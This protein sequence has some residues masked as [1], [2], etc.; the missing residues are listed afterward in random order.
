MSGAKRVAV[1]GGS[2]CPP[3]LGHLLA[4]T[5]A[6]GYGLDEVWVFPVYQHRFAKPLQADFATRLRWCAQTFA[7]LGP[8]VV[9][10]DDERELV[11]A[12]GTGATIHLVQHLQQKHPD[13]RLRLLVGTDVLAERQRWLQWDELA[14]LAPP[15]VLPRAGAAVDSGFV[16]EVLPLAVGDVSSTLLRERLG[17]RLPVHGWLAAAVADDPVLRAAFAAPADESQLQDPP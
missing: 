17:Q 12:G 15:L 4:A 8:R 7:P 16:G 11:R 14:Q 10:R 5:Y 2:F 3:H 9:I 1:Y 13:V 6:L